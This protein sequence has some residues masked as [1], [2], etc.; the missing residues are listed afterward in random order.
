MRAGIIN[1][2]ECIYCILFNNYVYWRWLIPYGHHRNLI[3]LLQRSDLHGGKHIAET[4]LCKMITT[5]W[6][7]FVFWAVSPVPSTSAVYCDVC[8]IWLL[9][10]NI[11][12]LRLCWMCLQIFTTNKDFQKITMFRWKIQ[13]EYDKKIFMIGIE[14]KIVSTY[15]SFLIFLWYYWPSVFYTRKQG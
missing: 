4:L 11:S 6:S 2:H 3:N 9:E 12:T 10:E 1:E 14:K 8:T 13:C 15:T 5:C 7:N